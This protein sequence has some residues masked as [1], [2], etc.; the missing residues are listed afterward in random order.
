MIIISGALFFTIVFAAGAAIAAII[1]GVSNLLGLLT[2]IPA[3]EILTFG[4]AMGFLD[5]IFPALLIAGVL[6]IICDKAGII[7]IE[8][9]K[10][11]KNAK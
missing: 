10:R 1:F 7:N 9:L 5:I 4:Q 3:E 2:L 6:V 11:I 8:S